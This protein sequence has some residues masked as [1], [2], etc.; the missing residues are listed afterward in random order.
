MNHFFRLLLFVCGFAITLTACTNE[1][2]GTPGTD[3]QNAKYTIMIYGCGGKN[4]DPQMDYA[5][6]DIAKA[7]NVSNNQVRVTVMYSMSKDIW[8]SWASLARPT[9]MNSPRM[10]ILP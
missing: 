8:I 3:G 7:L 6:D 5:I 4:V 2:N 9:A 1:D 10:S